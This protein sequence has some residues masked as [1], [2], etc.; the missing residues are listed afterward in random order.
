MSDLEK[1]FTKLKLML[2]LILLP[3]AVVEVLH[4]AGL[5]KGETSSRAVELQS[6]E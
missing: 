3:P 4:R 6:V 5:G 1:M 2:M